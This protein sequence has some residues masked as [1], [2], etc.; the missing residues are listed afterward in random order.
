[1]ASKK[2][3]DRETVKIKRGE[4]EGRRGRQMKRK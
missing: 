1:M 3:I 2:K 4:G